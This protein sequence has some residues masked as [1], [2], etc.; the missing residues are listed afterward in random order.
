MLLDFCIH[1]FMDESKGR[2]VD[3]R[4]SADFIMGRILCIHKQVGYIGA[5]LLLI[6]V[7]ICN[8]LK[9]GMGSYIG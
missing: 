3:R 7:F 6:Y 5:T 1:S 9:I 8:C 4:E 2:Y